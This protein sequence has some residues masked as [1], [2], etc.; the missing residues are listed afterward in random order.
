MAE[1]ISE[2]EFYNDKDV[3]TQIEWLKAH[4]GGA[5]LNDVRL[6]QDTD[7][8]SEHYGRVTM[9]F[10]MEDGKEYE[11]Y[12]DNVAV[13]RIEGQQEGDILHIKFYLANGQTYTVDCEIHTSATASWVS[14]TGDPHDNTALTAWMAEKE[15]AA[16]AAATFATGTQMSGEISDRQA[17][18]S[19]LSQRIDT[20][21]TR[22]D[23]IVDTLTDIL[24]PVGSIFMS[25]SSTNPG[26]WLTGTTWARY[27]MG[28]TIIGT[29]DNHPNQSTGGSETVTLQTAQMPNHNHTAMQHTHTG[30]TDIRGAHTHRIPHKLGVI[31]AR[32]AV[33]GS[34]NDG[35]TYY[36]ST[37][38]SGDHSHNLTINATDISIFATGG[39]QP[40]DNMMPFIATYIWVRTA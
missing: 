25:T 30:S 28:R 17:A 36:A 40:H 1:R 7:P 33:G 37:E 23:N 13:T 35:D 22:V 8:E 20:L 31:G 16:H 12:F 27:A 10:V 38:T 3:I 39:G 26:T 5:R 34:P 9:T 21:N 19:A 32:D 14:I 4:I 6:V 24:Y 11:R 2:L 15:N 29:S 18:D